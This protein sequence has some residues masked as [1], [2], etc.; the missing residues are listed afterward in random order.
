MLDEYETTDGNV[1]YVHVRGYTM[2]IYNVYIYN[3]MLNNYVM[4]VKLSSSTK[5]VD[6]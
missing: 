3:L 5:S 6:W 1:R 2:T 4:E